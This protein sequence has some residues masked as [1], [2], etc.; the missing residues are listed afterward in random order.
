LWGYPDQDLLVSVAIQV[1]QAIP[2]RGATRDKEAE[3]EIRAI[4]DRKDRL[5][6]PA[7]LATM[8][9]PDRE[10]ILDKMRKW[11]PKA[12][13]GIREQGEIQAF[14]VLPEPVDLKACLVTLD[15]KDHPVHLDV[16]ETTD[17]KDQPDRLVK[18]VH[19]VSTPELNC[20]VFQE[21]LHRQA[22]FQDFRAA[23]TLPR[24]PLEDLRKII[25]LK[26]IFF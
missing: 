18:L 12:P 16:K 15:P 26:K 9:T 2:D 22:I 10:E 13:R 20:Q 4:R 14:L 19:E 8:E 1:L 17:I 21:A 7:A 6:M 11:V 3:T 5:A 25:R 24:P 23:I